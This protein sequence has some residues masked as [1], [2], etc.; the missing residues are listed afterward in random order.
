[1]I[2]EHFKPNCFSFHNQTV[3]DALSGDEFLKAR[4]RANP[5]EFIR[6]AIF[7]NR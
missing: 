4:T 7:Q 5:Y 2:V 6:G 1:M 3:F